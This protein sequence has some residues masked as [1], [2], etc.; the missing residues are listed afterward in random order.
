MVVAESQPVRNTSAGLDTVPV[1]H[2]VRWFESTHV[3]GLGSKSDSGGP[4]T[5]LACRRIWKTTET[6][7]RTIEQVS[8]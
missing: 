5:W 7:P 1:A 3:D 8:L 6:V 2:N 4:R